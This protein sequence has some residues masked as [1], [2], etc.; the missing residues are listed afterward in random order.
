MPAEGFDAVFEAEDSGAV[1][2]VGA[3]DAVV[4]DGEVQ[5]V[6]GGSTVILT[7]VAWACLAVLVRASAT[8]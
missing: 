7:V 6:V 2:E 5:C 1:A 4:V 8:V 3:A